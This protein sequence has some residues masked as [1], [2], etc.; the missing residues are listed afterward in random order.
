[1]RYGSC[2][3]SATW[4]GFR[5]GASAASLE[6]VSARLATGRGEWGCLT[7]G[8][9]LAV[10]GGCRTKSR[11]SADFQYLLVLGLWSRIRDQ[12]GSLVAVNLAKLPNRFPAA[13]SKRH[14]G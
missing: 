7:E 11:K 10:T 6:S 14:R 8:A 2:S 9:D 13:F 5:T 3:A 1:M 4:L 12:P